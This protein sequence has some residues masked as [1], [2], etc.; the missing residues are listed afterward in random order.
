MK[1]LQIVDSLEAGGAERVCVDLA[2]LLHEKCV[3]VSV[4]TIIA[5][6]PLA[7][8]LRPG[9][10]IHCLWRKH[11][12]ELRAMVTLADMLK[13]Y[14]IIHVHMRYTFQYV[15]LVAKLFSI[16]K[17]IVLHDHYGKIDVDKSIP[18][19]LKSPLKPRYYIGVSTDLTDWAITKLRL[20][21]TRV[22]LLE[23]TVV[24]EDHCVETVSDTAVLVSNF[25]RIKN[26]LFAIQLIERCNL[27]LV[28]YGKIRDE[29]YFQEIRDYVFRR[30]LDGRVKF[31][32]SETNVQQH[33]GKYAFALHTALSESGPLVLIEYL[34]QSLPFLAYET[35]QV[36]RKIKGD[37]PEFF[38]SNF[39]L[40][41]WQARIERILQV[42][43]N[44]ISA[45]YERHFSPALYLKS[46]LDIYEHVLSN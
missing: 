42:D 14:D 6:G 33:L 9:I 12:F 35:G 20:N 10:P 41:E 25:D 5:I 19:F 34:A 46:C 7:S 36:A 44:Q 11:R 40:S 16:D 18:V 37:R 3:K 24:R 38:I 30:G 39:D 13:E 28:I 29:A 4:L 1:I 2:N 22:F 31:V 23:N 17:R 8:L 15:R 27:N 26:H 45:I 43:R 21:P 32:H